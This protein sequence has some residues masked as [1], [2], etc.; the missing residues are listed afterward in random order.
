MLRHSSF[1]PV[2]ILVALA[3]LLLLGCSRKPPVETF[4]VAGTTL[5]LRRSGQGGPT[6]VYEGGAGPYSGIDSGEKLLKR[7]GSRTTVVTYARAGRSPSG[8]ALTPRTLINVTSEL[9]ALLAAAGCRPPYVL[10][11]GSL[12]GIYV[13]A[14]AMRYP[15]EIAGLVLI[16]SAHER[17]WFEGDR[18]LG[19]A[20]G[21]ALKST[22][23]TLRARPDPVSV[24]EM[25]DLADVWAAGELGLPGK[26]PDVPLVAITGLK[27]DRAESQLTILR[28]LHGEVVATSTRG[29]HI[30][31]HK[32]GHNLFS[33][34]P[35]LV[36]DAV[37]W[38]VDAVGEKKSAP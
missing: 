37:R 35:E 38:V 5:A 29:R 9:H 19:L 8:P 12:G 18:L 21:T 25:E 22:I 31:S 33:S 2:S 27:P 13:R 28:R 32:S 17:L 26:V 11:G 3:A 23:D 30:V 4:E 24:R 16:E 15:D 14:F 10:V 1:L 6:I 7:F 20:P 36:F 34:E